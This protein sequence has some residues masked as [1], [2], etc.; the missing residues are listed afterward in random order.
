MKT[1]TEKQ[2]LRHADEDEKLRGFRYFT[3]DRLDLYRRVIDVCGQYPEPQTVLEVGPYNLPVYPD[4][5]VLDV[6]DWSVRMDCASA[7]K[8]KYL[9]DAGQVPWPVKKRYDLLIA[10]QVWEHLGFIGDHLPGENPFNVAQSLAFREAWRIAKRIV[11]TVPFG[12]HRHADIRHLLVTEGVIAEWTC[13]APA[14]YVEDV[15]PRR[16]MVWETA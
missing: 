2:M 16:I 6:A 10:M 14:V 1:L 4:C 3:D 8:P 5:D 11:L 13:H 12:I 9:H 7:P 15:G